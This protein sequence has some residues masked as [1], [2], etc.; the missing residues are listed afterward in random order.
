MH[1]VY[2]IESKTNPAQRYVGETA[3]VQKRL[4]AHNAGQSRHTSKYRPW[5]LVTC[6]AFS[7]V[8]KA[9]DFERYLKTGSGQAFSSKRLW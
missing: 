7:D 5:R 3:N 6:L 8:R 2:L 1:Y 4:A 9:R